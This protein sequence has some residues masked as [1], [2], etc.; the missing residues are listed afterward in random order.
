MV[1]V[2]LHV[3][4]REGHHML[5][6]L[7]VCF[8]QCPK[9]I[10]GTGILLNGG[11]AVPL[12]INAHR[13]LAL[14]SVG[15]IVSIEGPVARVDGCALL[16]VSRGRLDAMSDA[17]A[18]G[19][20][21]RGSWIRLRLEEGLDGVGVVRTHGHGG[22]VDVAVRHRDG[23]Q[24]LLAGGF[25]ALRELGHGGA[26]RG[27]A[28]LPSR[29]GVSFG[30]KHQH[31]HVGARLHHVVQASKAD[32][33]RPPVAAHQPHAVLHQVLGEGVAHLRRRRQ[34]LRREGLLRRDDV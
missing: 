2:C 28:A 25:A 15:W 13:V 19:D 20:D 17:V 9:S 27:L 6:G 26:R 4:L 14:Q 22:H 10:L 12:A 30:V 8:S 29:V 1:P 5:I 16:L 24:V 33:V 32:V 11:L 34:R 7:W 18:V 21:E 31:V 23:A 3:V